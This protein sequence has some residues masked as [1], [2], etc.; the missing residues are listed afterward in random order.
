MVS[1]RQHI[2]FFIYY[3]FKK[4]IWIFT[5]G[6]LAMLSGSLSASH[7]SEQPVYI[8]KGVGYLELEE[9]KSAIKDW[10]ASVSVE[11]EL[12]DVETS[13]D[14]QLDFQPYVNSEVTDPHIAVIP[15]PEEN[16]NYA[17]SFDDAMQYWHDRNSNWGSAECQD[18]FLA[19]IEGEP[20]TFE[21]WADVGSSWWP[22]DVDVKARRY[23]ARYTANSIAYTYKSHEGIMQCVESSAAVIHVFTKYDGYQ[24]YDG[25]RGWIT[26]TTEQ[27]EPLCETESIQS[28]TLKTCYAPYQWDFLYSDCVKKC[29]KGSPLGLLTGV[30]YQDDDECATKAHDP[31]L[32]K[33]GES[34]QPQQSDF[35]GGGSFPI[36]F[37]RNYKSYRV[38]DPELH[39]KRWENIPVSEQAA[40]D[41]YYQ[42]NDYTGPAIRNSWNWI[43]DFSQDIAPIG[44]RQWKHSYQVSLYQ[45][46]VNTV[47]IIRANGKKKELTLQADGITYLPVQLTGDQLVKVMDSDDN[48]ISWLYT[49]QSA[50]QETYDL[51]GRLILMTNPQGLTQSLAYDSDSQLISVTDAA[52]RV[53]QLGYDSANRLS[54]LVQPD[55]GQIQLSYDTNGNLTQ[56]VYPDDTPADLTNN[57]SLN[58]QYTDTRH[59]YALTGQVD[60][61]GDLYATWTFDAAGR[62]TGSSNHN[63]FKQG[64]VAYELDQA[65]IT[66]AN[67][68][69]RQ[70]SF[71]PTTNKLT[72][73]AGGNCG[74]CGSSDL[75]NYTYNALGQIITQT[76][77]NGV[78]TTFEYNSRGLQ[79]KRTEASAT[80]VSRETTTVWHATLSLPIE[81]AS[82]RAK[83]SLSYGVNGRIESVTQ[84]DLTNADAIDRQTLY[85]YLAEGLL[86]TITA[87]NGGITTYGYDAQKNLTGITNALGHVTQISNIDLNG[88]PTSLIDSNGLVTNLTYDIRGRLV[89]QTIN[90][91]TTTFSYD[92]IG[93][94]IQLTLANGNVTHYQYNGARLLTQ[95]SDGL[96]NQMIYSYDNVGNLLNVEV[97]DPLGELTRTQ[98]RVF[99]QLNR[100]TQQVGANNQVTEYGY[101]AVGNRISTKNPLLKET[102]FT[103]DGLNRLL[104]STDA[105]GGMTQYQYDSQ[106]HL[107]SVID[108]RDNTTSYVYDGFDNLMSQTSPD[109]ETTTFTYD[110]SGNQLSK[111]DAKNSTVNYRYDLLNRLTLIDYTGTDLDV[112]L[113][114]DQGVNG[115]GRL[116]SINDASGSTQYGYNPLGQLTSK[117]T[118]VADKTFVINYAYDAAGLLSQM[119]YPSTRQLSFTRGIDGQISKITSTL[120]GQTTELLSN[121]TYQPFGAA[122]SFMLGNG[123]SV[124]RQFDLDGRISGIDVTGIYQTVLG[125]NANS[126]IIQQQTPLQPLMQQDY[127]YDDLDRLTDATGLSGTSQYQYDSLGNRT[128]KT[129]ETEVNTLSYDP[130]SN[131]LTG[132]Y[133]HDANGNRI[134]DSRFNFQ[135]GEHNRL[136]EVAPLD[137]TDNSETTS[138]QYNGLGQRVKK[139]SIFGEVIYLYDEAGLVIAEADATG[140]ISKETIYFEGQPLTMM[141]GE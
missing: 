130:L 115:K 87:P 43:E 114:Y 45:G 33:T 59:P 35:I 123:K 34:Y 125:Y 85:Q 10:V 5:L 132:E 89:S 71:D 39:I 23:T 9:A 86:S 47:F 54:Q 26:P 107:I 129:H 112:S 127:A 116:T 79:T 109:T 92:K 78:A 93:Q 8:Y 81:I 122:A 110:I 101:D 95:V 136:S 20:L 42:P 28:L 84:S 68:Q 38:P 128:Q 73:V 29:K 13:D 66:E 60:E 134:S 126:N 96:N 37:T 99:D 53:L 11:S 21:G 31:I 7:S 111:T 24:C 36:R 119:T 91:N 40:W 70:L 140:V 19:D 105:L 67:G 27:G 102:L 108:P 82:L 4:S 135:Y 22:A 51:Q 121:A 12:Q 15:G 56:V 97:K 63:G 72:Q 100:L 133:Q 76:D 49:T 46:D 48:H 113:I 64:T 61:N 141:V 62:A 131:R 1:N 52:G 50:I 65:T 90:S 117:T 83:T 74:Q 137:A 98:S 30:C 77:F 58:Y 120:A 2:N 118:Q 55:G 6:I 139:T 94:L 80:A 3:H 16:N 88:R 69:T 44:Y 14:D 138:Y 17:D 18:S 57:P 124:S 25:Y 106:N 103:F 104:Q 41:I 32:T 75:A